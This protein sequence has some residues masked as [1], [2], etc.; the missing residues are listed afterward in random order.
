MI[1]RSS[2]FP[3]IT[4][5]V[6][7]E[8]LKSLRQGRSLAGSPLRH[9]A[10]VHDY[11]ARHHIVSG[12]AGQ[13]A[14]LRHVLAEE[15]IREL[16]R[17]RLLNDLP[18]DLPDTRAALLD[19]L[20]SDAAQNNMELSGWS[21]LYYRYI[22]IELDLQVGEIAS[23][24]GVV[25]RQV[26]R[27]MKRGYRRLAEAIAAREAVA[28]ERHRQHLRHLRLPPA[29]YGRLWGIHELLD[30]L[31]RATEA[32][33][34]PHTH[35]LTGMAG[36]GKTST[37]HALAAHLLSEGRI[38]DAAW[39]SL[40]GPANTHDVYAATA[41]E[42]DYPFLAEAAFDTLEAGLRA[43][44][45]E[46]RTILV[47]DNADWLNQPVQTLSSLDRLIRPGHLVAVQRSLPPSGAP[48]A[49]YHVDPMAPEVFAQYL[50]DTARR[51][52]VP[53]SLLRD[54]SVMGKLQA[55][56]G[57]NPLAGLVVIG[58]LRYLALDRV[59][60]SL[61][62]LTEQGS[63]ALFSRL[64]QT[65]W[66]RLSADAQQAAYALVFAAADS[67][68]WTEVLALSG[69]PP[70]ALDRALAQIVESSLVEAEAGA[71]VYSLHPLAR[72]FI[73][74]Q[75]ATAE[76]TARRSEMLTRAAPQGELVI[77][78]AHQPERVTRTLLMMKRELDA[79]PEGAIPLE[80]VPLVAPAARRS[81]QWTAW[82]DVLL[83]VRDRMLA[84]SDERHADSRARVLLELGVA[85]RWLGEWAEAA[86]ALQDAMQQFAEAA[87]HT[88]QAEALL[89]LGATQQA[90]GQTSAAYDAFHTAY[91]SAQQVG[92]ARLHR[93]AAN[94]LAALALDN[95]RPADALTLLAPFAAEGT[96]DA[97]TLSNL[98]MAYLY[99]GDATAAVTYERRALERY[100]TEGSLPEQARV[101][102]RLGMAQHAAG[103]GEA[104]IDHLKT[105]LVLM[106]Q[107]GD[108]LGEA[109]ALNNLGAA[110][111]VQRRPTDAL[112]IWR[113]ALGLLET[114]GDGVGLA[115]TW[116]NL[117]DLYWRTGQRDQAQLA[118]SE[119]R[120]LADHMALH[121]LRQI[122][123]GHPA[124][125]G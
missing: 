111:A 6:V 80:L 25:E 110:Y 24:A 108:A 5:K 123:D 101:H 95:D 65:T 62:E 74:T 19:A 37:A 38:E 98:G 49:V 67:V 52:A 82:R 28:R 115:Y 68:S 41:A 12:P 69:L 39:V 4:D 56:L 116:F 32:D 79:Q 99:Q 70:A 107:V 60:A 27:W 96:T 11:A 71:G 31:Y 42:L 54:N 16:L 14:A 89:E 117:G 88:G 21:A 75:A 122:L 53:V 30:V 93:R 97:E 100:E 46:R 8:A 35:I 36:A 44:L 119:A 81:G 121:A 40:S 104:A 51:K 29:S 2:Q 59:L 106:R 125:G 55:V 113:E 102:L 72:L 15:I 78:A 84:Q 33:A 120:G 64:F 17:H 63:E 77:P 43:K 34:P 7:E 1:E 87:D 85:H 18:A 103:E 105:A 92:D 76:G 45:A 118:M 23:L 20:R 73:E 61:P 124:A 112:S 91:R 83:R 90:M 48:G 47:L 114:L 66:G 13:S 58:Q 109:R 86:A 50:A 22:C 26:R 94:R 9:L 10:W 3:A 57:G